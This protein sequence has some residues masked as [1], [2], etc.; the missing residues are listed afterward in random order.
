VDGLIS[1]RPDLARQV[2]DDVERIRV[3]GGR[4]HPRQ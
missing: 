2:V 3:A 4:A 1:D